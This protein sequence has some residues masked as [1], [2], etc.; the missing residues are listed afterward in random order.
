[1]AVLDQEEEEPT[2]MTYMRRLTRFLACFM[3]IK[4]RETCTICRN[5][6]P[7]EAWLEFK[8]IGNTLYQSTFRPQGIWGNYTGIL[9]CHFM[10]LF[11]MVC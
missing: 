3:P 7:G 5:E 1:M 10:V 9:F 6:T 4:K 11:L 8:I 2:N